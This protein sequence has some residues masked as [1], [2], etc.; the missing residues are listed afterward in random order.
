MGAFCCHGNQ[1]PDPIWPKTLCS[2]SPTPMMLL[3]KFGSDRPIGLRDIHVWK[4]E[5]TDAGTDGRRL[6]WYTISSPLSLRLRWA[7]EHENYTSCLL[8]SIVMRLIKQVIWKKKSNSTAIAAYRANCRTAGIVVK[9]P[10]MSMVLWG[11][12]WENL[13]WGFLS[14]S[15]TNQ[16]VHPQK[17]AGGLKFRT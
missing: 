1:S 8:A 16:V 9:A 15:D 7:N 11:V 10:E 12:S 5:Q 14:R 6:D 13:F 17:M 4:C 3:I 2:Q